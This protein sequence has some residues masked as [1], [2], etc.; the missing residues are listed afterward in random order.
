ML[1]WA[2]AREAVEAVLQ[3]AEYVKGP[4]DDPEIP[5]Y[6]IGRAAPDDVADL[7]FF[8]VA[9]RG[10]FT[11][12][13]SAQR[14]TYLVV[15]AHQDPEEGLEEEVNKVVAALYGLGTVEGGPEGQLTE[16]HRAITLTVQFDVLEE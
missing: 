16:S 12:T 4:V 13:A 2:E 11:F 15:V 9:R 1:K 5:Q 10:G 3:D 6:F 14:F 7:E 8:V